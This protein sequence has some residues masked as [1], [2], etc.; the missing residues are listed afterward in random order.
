M[1]VVIGRASVLL[2]NFHT[3]RHAHNYNI[4]C[5]VFMWSGTKLINK[6]IKLINKKPVNSTLYVFKGQESV[7]SLY[8]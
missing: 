5:F 1:G 7:V 2:C 6:K 3:H 4:Y 8:I